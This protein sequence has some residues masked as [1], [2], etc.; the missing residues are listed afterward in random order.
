MKLIRIVFLIAL[1][2]F[3][4]FSQTIR[5]PS[6]DKNVTGTRV[7]LVAPQEFK[8]ASKFPGFEYAPSNASIVVTELPA[9]VSKISAGFS[10]AAALKAKNMQILSRENVTIDGWKGILVHLKQSAQGADYLKWI[11]IFGNEKESVLITA[12][13]P[14]QFA[15]QFSDRLKA[16]VLSAKWKEEKDVSITEG[17]NYTV[18]E[19]GGFKLAKRITNSLAYTKNALFP[20]KNIDDPIFIVSQ[21]VSNF[22]IVKREEFSKKRILGTATVSQVKITKSEK[23]VIDDLEGYKTFAAGIDKRTGKPVFIYQVMLFETGNYFIMQG[24]VSEK[25]KQMYLTQ[26][27]EMANSFKKQ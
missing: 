17:L 19:T 18:D 11:T 10:D 5:T 21:T 22:D 12:T 23:I 27:E 1:F 6:L 13:F 15:A 16:S 9:P 14:K 2:C 26:F 24:I 4:I 25:N 20:N 8:A 7:N 3:T